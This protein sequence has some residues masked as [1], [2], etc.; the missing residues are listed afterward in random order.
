MTTVS[1]GPPLL[2]VRDLGVTYPG[3]RPWPW[4]R[5]TPFV[6]LAQAGFTLGPGEALGIVGESGSGK[7]SLARALLRLVPLAAG[8]VLLRGEDLAILS[9]AELRQRR[10][11]LQMIFQ[12]P[13]GSLNP[14]QT[15]RDILTEPL[16]LYLPGMPASERETRLLERL[17]EV[18]LDAAALPR[19][20]TAFSGGQAQRIAIAR[21]L[22][23]DPEILVCDEPDSALDLST[24]M[25]V[26]RLLAEQRRSRGLA[27]VF[28]SH[29]L[30]AVN[31]LCDQVLVL[32]RGLVAEQG[33]TA[34]VLRAPRDPYTRRLLDAVPVPDPHRARRRRPLP[35]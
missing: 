6:A 16:R 8:Q 1:A 25:Q 29:D 33:A 10:R 23:A 11:H 34:D 26:L 22:M 24:R 17:A 15:V 5:A 18:G 2:E 4:R 12:D 21:A 35:G 7:T 20:P 30:G 27:L 13:V 28:I 19:R 14:R 31:F 32:H 9:P 3:R